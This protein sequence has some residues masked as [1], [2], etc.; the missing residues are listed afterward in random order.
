MEPTR[1]IVVML[2]VSTI[3][4]ASIVGLPFIVT[5]LSQPRWALAKSVIVFLM[6]ASLASLIF[7]HFLSIAGALVIA[8][9]SHRARLKRYAARLANESQDLPSGAG[10]STTADDQSGN[11][12]NST[13]PI[14]N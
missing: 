6:T 8:M 7:P 1:L 14:Q 12:G 4:V 2:I 3:V 9:I 10:T 5:R 13:Q 11:A